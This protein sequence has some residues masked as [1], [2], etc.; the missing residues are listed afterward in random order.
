MKLAK[1]ESAP[2]LMHERKITIFRLMGCIYKDAHILK[3]TVI[4]D[5]SASTRTHKIFSGLNFICLEF[6]LEKPIWLESNITDFQRH[7]K[8]RFTQDNFIEELDFDYLSIEV[9]EEG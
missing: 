7:S 8:T 3:S 4:C 5:E 1:T 2:T 6:D 9:I